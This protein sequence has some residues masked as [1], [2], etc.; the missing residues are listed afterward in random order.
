MTDTIKPLKEQPAW[1]P[2]VRHRRVMSELSLRSLFERD[3]H[4]FGRFSLEH[5]GVLLDYSKNRVTGETME[6]LVDL[7]RQCGLEEQREAMFSGAIV[8]TSERRAVLHTALRDPAETPLH[9]EGENV[10]AE[11][12]ETARRMATLVGDVR[13]G[14]Y[15]GVTGK[16][17]TDV[18]NIGIGGSDLGPRLAIEAMAP[19]ADGP[20]VH[21]VAN[22]DGWEMQQV[23]RS[24]DPE[25]TLFIVVS[26]SFGT[27]ETMTNAEQAMAWFARHVSDPEGLKRHFLGVTANTE[28]VDQLGLDAG[29]VLPMWD[30]VGGRYS[31]WSAV[32]LSVAM[33]V[34]MERFREMLAGAHSMDRHFREAPLA[35]NIPAI[36]GLLSVWHV[37]FFGA[38]SHAIVSYTERLAR[39][40]AYLQ[41]LIMES[42]GKS[43]DREGR[44][45]DWPTVP[46]IWGQTGTPAQHAFFQ[47]LHQGTETVPVDFV[48][49]A[50]AVAEDA[51]DTALVTA[52]LLAQSQALM[53]GKSADEARAE[54]AAAG[55]PSERIDE[56]AT[57]RSCPGGRPSNTL[58]L[59]DLTPHRFGML[60]AA[61][62]HRTFVEG[63]IWGINSFDQ[64]GVELGKQLASGL[65]PALAEDAELPDADSSTRGLIDRARAW[66]G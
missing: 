3:P 56:L 1:L 66:R 58:L 52:N 59:K 16:A 19:W 21:F 43:V 36:M 22:V 33:A 47:A 39:L 15:T 34:G 25:R 32:G 11:I 27:P 26:K 23:F 62:E 51:G 49:V 65:M 64:W 29:R 30:W 14:A 50:S 44:P 41:Q 6:L 10:R 42:N 35:E 38:R 5:D 8:N 17:I 63:V 24:V 60:V 45:V 57:A 31:V 37:T 40:P 61:Y 7:A 18:V 55:L 53:Q 9:V 54:M 46:V 12:L 20:R 28:K 13:S 2:L 48:G 4:R